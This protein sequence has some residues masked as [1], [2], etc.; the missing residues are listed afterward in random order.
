[1]AGRNIDNNIGGN[2]L[3]WVAVGR[4]AIFFSALIVVEKMR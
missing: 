2:A 1:M 3:R 4:K